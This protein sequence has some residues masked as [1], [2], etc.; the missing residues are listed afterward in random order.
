MRIGEH[1]AV[2]DGFGFTRTASE[3]AVGAEA[4]QRLLA[5]E[6]RGQLLRVERVVLQQVERRGFG[7]GFAADHAQPAEL[8]FQSH[9]LDQAARGHGRRT[10]AIFHLAREL[11]DLG[12]VRGARQALVQGQA[13][14][15][16]G[17]VVFGQERLDVEVEVGVHLVHHG[18]ARSSCV[19]SSNILQN[20]SKPTLSTKPLCSAPQQ[21]AA[22]A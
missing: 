18:F 21:I 3:P 10:K 6:Q 14:A 8:G 19:A 22:A 20:R 2:R 5:R 13:H 11:V 1:Q 4:V 12:V 16:F 7:A 9:Q 17:D 15:D